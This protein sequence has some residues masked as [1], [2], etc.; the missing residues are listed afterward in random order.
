MDADERAA[1]TQLAGSLDMEESLVDGLARI[2]L[3]AQQEA[4]DQAG[5]D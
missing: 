1:L 2:A 5:L 3:A 4:G